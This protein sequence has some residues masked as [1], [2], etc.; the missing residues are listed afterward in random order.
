MIL[1]IY[2][3]EKEMD[4]VCI[5]IRSACDNSN[6]KLYDLCQYIKLNEDEE[7]INP[8]KLFDYIQLQ[9][10][11]DLGDDISNVK[12]TIINDHLSV[13]FFYK[14]FDCHIWQKNNLKGH[15]YWVV[16]V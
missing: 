10:K 12:Y 4:K 14:G 3:Y 2:I 1:F 11:K 8:L 6:P 9:L 7:N 5:F 16:S 15:H 13:D